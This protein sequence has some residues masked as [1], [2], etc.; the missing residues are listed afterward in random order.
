MRLLRG[1]KRSKTSWFEDEVLWGVGRREGFSDTNDPL[2]HLGL[3]QHAFEAGIDD[4]AICG[5]EPPR[6]PSGRQRIPR[7]QLA[8]AGTDNPQ[9]PRCV[10][11]IERRHVVDDAETATQQV[12]DEVSIQPGEVAPRESGWEP[13]QPVEAEAEY[14][15]PGGPQP[16]RRHTA[17]RRSVRRGGIVIVK[18]GHRSA[19]VDV[20]PVGGLS[21]MV[22]V[23]EPPL[24]D[25][26]VASVTLA[27]E[28][29]ARITLNRAA[30]APVSV[31]WYL[32]L[33]PVERPV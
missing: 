30:P 15:E 7:P 18:A 9:C 24:K 21:G 17:R 11:L 4:R 20:P 10:A 16:G 26:R 22:A 2:A 8:L 31:T 14:H 23:V 19:V 3:T 12:G 33:S 5:F 27:D 1:S 28:G 13:R 29:K 32:V 6:R 25:V